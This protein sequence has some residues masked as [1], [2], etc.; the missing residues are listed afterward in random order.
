MKT[1]LTVFALTTLLMTAGLFSQSYAE[2]AS[3]D[4]VG[5]IH[6]RAKFQ[7]STEDAVVDNFKVFDQIEGFNVPGTKG[8]PAAKFSLWGAP[9]V[10]HMLLYHAADVIHTGV[11]RSIDPSPEFDAVVEVYQ[12]D[13][14]FRSFSYHDCIV[15]NY[16]FTTLHDGDETFSGKTKFV[17]AD[18]FEFQCNGYTPDCPFHYKPTAK[19]DTESTL[20]YKEKSLS[21]WDKAYQAN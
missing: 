10:S 5:D 4:S 16:K 18:A 14:V 2:I 7:F 11:Q 20:D 6:I 13:L 19:A 17:Y 3:S 15:S 12:G 8:L 9:D 1:I 21:T